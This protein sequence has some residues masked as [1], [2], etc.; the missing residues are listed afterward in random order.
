MGSPGPVTV[1]VSGLG[2][3]MTA[4]LPTGGGS[5]LVDAAAYLAA[6]FAHQCHTAGIL[7]LGSVHAAVKVIHLV[8]KVVR[9]IATGALGFSPIERHPKETTAGAAIQAG[10]RI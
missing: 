9:H 5:V 2:F 1:R 7:T 6:H 10:G 8:H 3:A 4:E